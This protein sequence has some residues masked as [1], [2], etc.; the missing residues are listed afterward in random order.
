MVAPRRSTSTF[1]FANGAALREPGGALPNERLQVRGERHMPTV[2]QLQAELKKR[3]LQQTGKKAEL[4]ARLAE[5]EGAARPRITRGW[6]LVVEHALSGDVPAREDDLSVQERGKKAQTD[7]TYNA[8]ITDVSSAGDA[9]P[10]VVRQLWKLP[11]RLWKQ[12]VARAVRA[13]ALALSVYQLTVCSTALV[14]GSRHSMLAHG[15]AEAVPALPALVI[16]VLALFRSSVLHAALP[17]VDGPWPRK[18][19]RQQLDLALAAGVL[20]LLLPTAPLSVS[21]PV[22]V[23]LLILVRA[24]VIV[25]YANR[26]AG[27]CVTAVVPA[28]GGYVLWC[29]LKGWRLQDGSVRLNRLQHGGLAWRENVSAAAEEIARCKQGAESAPTLRICA[30]A[31]VE[32]LGRMHHDVVGNTESL[33]CWGVLLSVICHSVV[34]EIARRID[35]WNV[36]QDAA[37]H[38]AEL[39][40]SYHRDEFKAAFQSIDRDND[41][42]ISREELRTAFFHVGS[43]AGAAESLDSID[44]A[45]DDTPQSELEKIDTL[46]SAVDTNRDGKIDYGEFEKMMYLLWTIWNIRMQNSYANI[47]VHFTYVLC[48]EQ[49]SRDRG[50]G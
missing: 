6:S 28:L 27:A 26:I 10:S 16:A 30:E 24:S 22:S 18:F 21:S 23:A 44:L 14:D 46:I 9:A 3:G 49:V 38:W 12:R 34:V 47:C 11:G 19:R 40:Q 32:P 35:H 50:L 41:K 2:K 17:A 42:T 25:R 33:L 13:V 43:P 29:M 45:S 7:A 48:A 5:D 8:A 1:F 39:R 37:V 15:G 36:R 20:L 31:A 4:E